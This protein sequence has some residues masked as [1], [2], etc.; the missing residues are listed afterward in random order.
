MAAKGFD[1]YIQNRSR[2]PKK[3]SHVLSDS[4]L[5]STF[6]YED[7]TYYWA[8]TDRVDRTILYTENDPKNV[9]R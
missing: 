9:L 5:P 6:I 8:S 4:K 2:K 3:V 7:K 1:V